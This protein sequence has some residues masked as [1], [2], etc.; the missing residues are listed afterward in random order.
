MANRTYFQRISIVNR[1]TISN[2]NDNIIRQPRAHIANNRSG[3]YQNYTTSNTSTSN[4]S[5][6][7]RNNLPRCS[8]MTVKSTPCQR[9]GINPVME[10]ST[11]NKD[12]D[13][14]VRYYCYQHDPRMVVS[15]RCLGYVKSER[16]QCRITCSESEIRSEGRPICNTHY[17]LG[18]RLI[19]R[20][21]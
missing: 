18:A 15:R 4:S 6:A 19:T 12:S 5:S 2:T 13:A 17:R 11:V 7:P 21:N 3:S 9:D 20:R 16:R 1:P 14:V 8:G 10:S